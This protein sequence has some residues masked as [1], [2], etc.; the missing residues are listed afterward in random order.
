M[1]G[2]VMMIQTVCL[3][4]AKRIGAV[5]LG[6]VILWQVSVHSGA[7][8]G[9]AIVHVAT[10]AVEITVDDARYWIETLWDTP[11]VCD[12]RPG[13]HRVRMVRD[14]RVVYEEEFTIAAGQELILSAW[15]GYDDGRGPRRALGPSAAW[16]IPTG[17]PGQVGAVAIAPDGRR[18]ATAGAEG[19]VVLW[20]V[21][22]GVDRELPGQP[23][24]AMHSLAFSPDGAV[25]AAGSRD[26]TVGLWDLATGRKRA[27]LRGH[28]GPVLCVA[29]TPDGT[30]LAA[31]SADESIRLWDLATGEATS[32]LRGH[33][34]AVG[35]IAFAPQGR[36]LASGCAGGQV[37]LWDVTGHAGRERPG[38]CSH[39]SAIQTLAFSPE[40]STLASCGGGEGVKL[41]DVA[42]GQPRSTLRT[43][44]PFVPA[45]GFST[46]GRMLTAVGS[47][48]GIV[49][50]WE[51]AS[52][53]EQV[54]FQ[55]PS[56]VRSAAFSPDG[57]RLVTGGD[58]AHARVW[59]L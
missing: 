49:Q 30:R 50:R 43:E 54:L 7:S 15:D 27:A 56:H 12:L 4:L 34:R 10:P 31:G 36:I 6:S 9:R 59:D 5:A 55:V 14:A 2:I 48:A 18:I 57:R 23:G 11:I 22:R 3:A 42:T 16:T 51:I 26:G 35:R 37:K 41:W 28:T 8:K 45:V 21:G 24:D 52:G 32:V 53:R 17:H 40:G 29:F 38:R 44:Q 58:D 33:R 46:D 1:R 25:L 19:G 13:C 39:R 20:E 47:I